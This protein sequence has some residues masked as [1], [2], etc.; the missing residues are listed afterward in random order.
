MTHK[1]LLEA[2]DYAA[3][4]HR[5][6]RRK[7]VEQLPYINHPISVATLLA[8]EGQ[9]DE[10]EVLI[11]AILH[12]LIEDTDTSGNDIEQRFGPRVRQY[13]E[14]VTDN[15]SLPK[16]QRKQ[17]QIEHAARG[18]DQAKLV[19]L[20]DKICNIRDLTDAPPAGW[21]VER[22]REYFDWA[23]SVVDQLGGVNEALEKLFYD[24][25]KKRP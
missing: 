7:D 8:T 11:T 3:H 9:V 20:A 12:D 4:R 6:Q 18:S 15:K 13:V 23:K 16:Q 21:D 25:Y 17:L 1:R 5:H 22:R 2:I 24:H 19:K 10:P 14:E